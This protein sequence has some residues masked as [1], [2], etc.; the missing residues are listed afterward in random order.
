MLAGTAQIPASS[1][2]T[3]RYRL[4]RSGDRQLNRAIYTVVLTRLR[5]DPATRAYAERRRGEGRTDRESAAAWAA[6]S[7][8]SLP[9]ARKPACRQL[10]T[11]HRSVP[12]WTDWD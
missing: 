3:V 6:T 1:G 7:P 5:L 4:N 8:A 11:R 2:K 10:L 9:T 12:S